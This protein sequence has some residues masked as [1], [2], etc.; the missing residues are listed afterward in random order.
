LEHWSVLNRFLFEVF[1]DSS[2]SRSSIEDKVFTESAKTT[3]THLSNF[4]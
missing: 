3:S 2:T 4:W 1:A